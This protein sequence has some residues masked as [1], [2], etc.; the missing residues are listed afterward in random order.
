M[1]GPSGASTRIDYER[2]GEKTPSRDAGG[3]RTLAR[4]GDRGVLSGERP[5]CD[6]AHIGGRP[7]PPVKSKARAPARPAALVIVRAARRERRLA[8]ASAGRGC[9]PFELQWS[10]QPNLQ[11]SSL[12]L[13]PSVSGRGADGATTGPGARQAQ[14]LSRSLPCGDA[15]CDG[16]D[17]SP[18][19]RLHVPHRQG[20]NRQ[21]AKI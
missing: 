9:E 5:A 4:R 8:A 17:L 21:C 16:Q 13:K 2:P 18:P 3:D 1:G 20:R 19:R 12:R 10:M 7:R 14:S 6:D 15:S 11:S